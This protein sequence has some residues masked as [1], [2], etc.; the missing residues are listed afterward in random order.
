MH[1]V[2]A[3]CDF[4]AVVASRCLPDDGGGGFASPE[5]DTQETLFVLADGVLQHLALSRGADVDAGS[6]ASARGF[7]AGSAPEGWWTARDAP[8]ARL[9]STLARRPRRRAADS[10][11]APRE[12]EPIGGGDPAVGVVGILGGGG[13]W[14]PPPPLP[15]SR[16]KALLARRSPPSSDR[17]GRTP[18]RRRRSSRNLYA[19]T[20][21]LLRYAKPRRA[22]RLPASV[23]ALARTKGGAGDAADAERADPTRLRAAARAAADAA[24]AAAAAQD[25]IE[26]ARRR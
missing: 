2:S 15:P 23:L 16:C 10:N 18:R 8:L 24:A 19:A 26:A 7:G 9:A 17:E 21:S 3:W 4:V 1:L 11:H 25:E 13:A 22:A 6:F 5:D 14:C 12:L 20:T